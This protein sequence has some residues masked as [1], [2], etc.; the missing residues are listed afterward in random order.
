[1]EE[2][3]LQIKAQYM[4]KTVARN[5]CAKIN[6]GLDVVG[7]REDGYHLMDMVMHLQ[8]QTSRCRLFLT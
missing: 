1:M 4:T 7:V 3:A 6:L 2:A 5:A 8:L